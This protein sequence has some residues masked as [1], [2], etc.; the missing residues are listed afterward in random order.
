MD[1]LV[2]GPIATKYNCFPKNQSEQWQV[3]FITK[4]T[5]KVGFVRFQ[6][7]SFGETPQEAIAKA[8][9]RIT[10]YPDC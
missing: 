4:V 3:D 9:L 6:E 2:I 1:W 8:V 10:K 7:C 5:D